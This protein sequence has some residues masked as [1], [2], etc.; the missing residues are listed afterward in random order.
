[1]IPITLAVEDPLSEAVLRAILRQSGRPYHVKSCIGLTGFGYLRRNIARLNRAAR[2]MP[3]LVLTDLDRV[4]CAPI[5][6]SEWLD[7]PLHHNLLFRVAVREVE[8]W[9]MAHRKE[10]AA[11]LGIRTDLIPPVPDGLED[12]KRT[13]LWLTA[14]SRKR[15]LR[16]AIIPPMKSTAKVGPDYNG[17][18]TQF[19]MASWSVREAMQYSVSL[20]KAFQAVVSFRPIQERIPHRH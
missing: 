5:L 10:F 13:L 7:V 20:K 16:E 14:K 6:L 2:E 8:A 1:M 9:I 17:Q 15:D 11:F 18:L 19:V 4:E 3:I 12:P